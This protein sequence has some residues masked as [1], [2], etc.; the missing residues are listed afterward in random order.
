M[1]CYFYWEY[2]AIGWKY[3]KTAIRQMFAD[4][5]INKAFIFKTFG[6]IFIQIG[7]MSEWPKTKLFPMFSVCLGLYY[8]TKQPFFINISSRIAFQ[9]EC[10][11]FYWSRAWRTVPVL[12]CC[13]ARTWNW[14][15]PTRRR[16]YGE[17]RRGTPPPLSFKTTSERCLNLLINVGEAHVPNITQGFQNKPAAAGVPPATWTFPPAT[18]RLITGKILYTKV[19]A[20]QYDVCYVPIG[21]QTKHHLFW[22]INKI[23]NTYR[24]MILIDSDSDL[25]WI[26]EPSTVNNKLKR[27]EGSGSTGRLFD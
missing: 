7:C 11:L 4:F 19:Q 16:S 24:K 25:P 12:P 20:N 26:P 6:G 27:R 18:F 3:G 22:K 15:F 9:S 17:D 10:K 1:P 2:I 23:N 5:V 13:H 14:I 21:I 8:T